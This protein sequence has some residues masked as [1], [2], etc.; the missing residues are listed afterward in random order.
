[1]KEI[2]LNSSYMRTKIFLLLLITA[3]LTLSFTFGTIRSEKT[4]AKPASVPH[5]P[6]GGLVINDDAKN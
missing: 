4:L 5:E 6:V 1:M 3:I 2:N